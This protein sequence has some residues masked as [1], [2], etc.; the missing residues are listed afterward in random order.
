MIKQIG[1]FFIFVKIVTSGNFNNSTYLVIVTIVIV[2]ASTRP[3]SCLCC[4]IV[5]DH[6]GPVVNVDMTMRQVFV[7]MYIVN[8]SDDHGRLNIVASPSVL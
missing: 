1:Y 2:F 3:G 6:L 5:E 7:K 8:F 4:W